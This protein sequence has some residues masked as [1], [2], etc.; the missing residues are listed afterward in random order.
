[1]KLS[2]AILAASLGLA[3]AHDDNGQHMPKLV[4]GRKFLSGFTARRQAASGDFGVA[5]RHHL[6]TSQRGDLKERQDDA[7]CGP[8]IGSC[9][10]GLCCSAEGCVSADLLAVRSR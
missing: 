3:L 10:A 6:S 4:G 8:G 9:A 5:K 1:M 2:A 7:R